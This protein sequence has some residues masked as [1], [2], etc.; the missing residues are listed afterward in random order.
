[1]RF[2]KNQKAV[3]LAGII[4]ALVMG[5]FPPWIMHGP[6]GEN[7]A[8]IQIPLGY[9]LIFA[10]PTPD[11]EWIASTPPYSKRILS[12]LGGIRLDTARLAT[13]WVTIAFVIIGLLLYLQSGD[14]GME[15]AAARKLYNRIAANRHRIKT[16]LGWLFLLLLLALALAT[17]FLPS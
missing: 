13:E 14:E 7:L 16:L 5:L 11:A 6:L 3:L 10:P 12:Q 2:N 8:P 9:G 4:A 17:E 1:M 15:L